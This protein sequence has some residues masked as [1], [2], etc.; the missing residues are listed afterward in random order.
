MNIG[1]W[2]ERKKYNNMAN[3]IS[4]EFIFTLKAL[5]RI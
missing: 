2:I 5:V 4:H 1:R 3:I